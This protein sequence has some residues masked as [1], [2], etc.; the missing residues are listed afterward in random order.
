MTPTRLFLI[1]LLLLGAVFGLWQLS[2]SQTATSLEVELPQANAG[3]LIEGDPASMTGLSIE[4]PRFGITVSLEYKDNRWAITNP[5]PDHAEPFVVQ[6]ALQALFTTH[7]EPAPAGWENQSEEEL[8]LLPA[9]A[10]IEVSF[11]GGSVQQLIIG[12]EEPSGNWQVAKCNGKLVRFPI[13]DFR[14]LARP[15]EQWRDHRLHEFGA[16]VT[17]VSWNPVE[18]P[19]ILLEKKN[20]RWYLRAPV[21]APLEV[22]SEPYL[23]ALLGG[24]VEGLGDVL[25]EELPLEKKKGDLIF[26]S[27]NR[28]VRL[29]V[30]DGLVVSDQRKYP[31]SYE[32][33]TYRFLDIPL[34]DLISS[35]I[36]DLNPER[37][38]SVKIEYGDASKIFLRR[39]DGWGS[40]NEEKTNPED[41][42]FV[43]ALLDYGQRLERGEAL[44]LPEESP[45][46]R[47]LYSISRQPKAKG[48][49][50]LRWWAQADGTVLVASDPGSSAYLSSVNFELGVKSLFQ[51]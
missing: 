48:S 28:Q 36:L 24:R 34:D 10:L 39:G 18:G 45:S 47:I 11:K 9:A 2:H 41:S 14:M 43:T 50:I 33:H 16:G 25:L 35:R 21:Q 40:Y 42:A 38:S 7:W 4:Q 26:T 23:M 46:G 17:Q 31:F 3:T 37:I 6:A 19:R 8:G 29:Q 20:N 22:R 13:P 32:E 1:C 49:Q 27:G 5:M 15:V 51:N 12:A 44:S 30:F